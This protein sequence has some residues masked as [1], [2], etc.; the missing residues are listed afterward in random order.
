MLV[1]VV[2]LSK[3]SGFAV[4]WNCLRHLENASIYAAQLSNKR[5]KRIRIEP[6][7]KVSVAYLWI[8]ISAAVM[9]SVNQNSSKQYS[10]F[11]FD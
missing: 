8:L 6:L 1:K 7:R 3:C 2:S 5:N 4:E 10:A 11:R 9:I